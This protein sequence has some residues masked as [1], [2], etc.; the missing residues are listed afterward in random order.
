MRGSVLSVARGHLEGRLDAPRSRGILRVG[1]VEDPHGSPGCMNVHIRYRR[2]IDAYRI[3]LMEI[4]PTRCNEVDDQVW[5]W[6]ERWLVN[7]A[8]VDPTRLMSAREIAEEFGFT[9]QNVRDWARRHPDRVPTHKQSDGRALY[10]L[11]D[12]LKYRSG[13]G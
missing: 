10:R 13:A 6:G 3:A 7:E 12:V 4:S 5:R 1:A 9:E 2:L 8:P 11:R